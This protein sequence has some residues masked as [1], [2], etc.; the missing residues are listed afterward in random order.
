MLHRYTASLNHIIRDSSFTP[1]GSFGF[2]YLYIKWGQFICKLHMNINIKLISRYG[3]RHSGWRRVRPTN[4]GKR[5]FLSLGSEIIGGHS[6]VKWVE[7]MEEGRT[8]FNGWNWGVWIEFT[9]WTKPQSS[10]RFQ[11]WLWVLS[12]F[13]CW[14]FSWH[15]YAEGLVCLPWISTYERF[16]EAAQVKC[17]A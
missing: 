1:S 3:S 10:G 9:H 7:W 12:P 13:E 14:A 4:S 11:N 15:A 8:G 16:T 6:P 5:L 17:L 2:V